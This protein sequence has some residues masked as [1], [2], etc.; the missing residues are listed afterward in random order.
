MTTRLLK[1]QTPK[2]LE[3]TPDI[4]SWGKEKAWYQVE[5]KLSSQKGFHIVLT[6]NQTLGRKRLSLDK[7]SAMGRATP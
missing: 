1:Q 6:A 2:K 3:F 5:E 4:S 7:R